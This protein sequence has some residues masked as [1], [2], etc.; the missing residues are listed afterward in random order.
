MAYASLVNS[1]MQLFNKFYQC[2]INTLLFH[3]ITW[4]TYL[5]LT[6]FLQKS[7]ISDQYLF[8]Y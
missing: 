4:P 7:E 3:E 2:S 6:G 1:S 8:E 5:D